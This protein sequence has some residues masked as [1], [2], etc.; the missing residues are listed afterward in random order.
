VAVIDLKVS[1]TREIAAIEVAV[2]H[3]GIPDALVK[4]L[5]G[6]VQRES[7]SGK[8]ATFPSASNEARSQSLGCYQADLG[9]SA[10]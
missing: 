4:Q 9:S 7:K 10:S 3:V 1:N 5:R 8:T 6:F 2:L